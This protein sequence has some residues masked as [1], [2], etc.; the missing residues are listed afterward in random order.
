MVYC[1][2]QASFNIKTDPLCPND[3]LGKG[4]ALHRPI[5]Y[6]NP[7]SCTH[8]FHFHFAFSN[9]CIIL[10]CI[11]YR[12]QSIGYRFQCILARDFLLGLSSWSFL[13]MICYNRECKLNFLI[14]SKLHVCTLYI[15]YIVSFLIKLFNIRLVISH[16][17]SHN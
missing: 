15:L 9:F 11:G 10:I 6:I 16:Y 14:V 17:G 5:S 12:F 13:D 3:N 7:I 1:I 8:R 4:S 2:S